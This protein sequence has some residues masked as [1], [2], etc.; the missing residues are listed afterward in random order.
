M[1]RFFFSRLAHPGLRNEC[2]GSFCRAPGKGPFDFLE[3]RSGDGK[4]ERNDQK[5]ERVEILAILIGKPPTRRNTGN[6]RQ[7][8]EITRKRA[9]R[10][11]DRRRV[12][13]GLHACNR[14][15]HANAKAMWQIGQDI[16]AH[17]RRFGRPPPLRLPGNIVVGNQ[18][19][20][21]ADGS[22]PPAGSDVCRQWK[23]DAGTRFV[24]DGQELK[25]DFFPFERFAGRK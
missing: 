19:L 4:G 17:D 9:Q 1:P 13:L 6:R 23:S 10:A 20:D 8:R 2:E 3:T 5:I 11:P 14:R 21:S 16:A 15:R 25:D 24:G 12:G 22:P 7:Q 18:I